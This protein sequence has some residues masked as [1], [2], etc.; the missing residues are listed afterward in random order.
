MG[1]RTRARWPPLSSWR[2]HGTCLLESQF[3]L[4]EQQKHN[5]IMHD[6]H[7]YLT[8]WNFWL[9]W[10]GMI[11]GWWVPC[12]ITRACIFQ[13][14]EDWDSRSLVKDYP[15]RLLVRQRCIWPDFLLVKILP[16]HSIDLEDSHIHKNAGSSLLAVMTNSSHDGYL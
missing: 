9:C 5:Q 3:E 6:Q 13:Q 7:N 8:W 1:L 14:I 12:E 15:W 2:A 4:P 16:Q 10:W 11:V